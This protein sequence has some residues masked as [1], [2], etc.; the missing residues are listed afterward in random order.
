MNIPTN[1]DI[2]WSYTV[3]K[4]KGTAKQS[5]GF[6]T[7]EVSDDGGN[8]TLDIETANWRGSSLYR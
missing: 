2:L 8:A 1:E 3:A 5:G 4:K 6:S 7:Y